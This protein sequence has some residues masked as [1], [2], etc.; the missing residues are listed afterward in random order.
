MHESVTIVPDSTFLSLLYN[1]LI[2]Y[3]EV[4]KKG[5]GDTSSV[6]LQ[7]PADSFKVLKL[8]R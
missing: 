3:I 1:L 5:T 7:Q 2:C 6:K 8:E 4:T